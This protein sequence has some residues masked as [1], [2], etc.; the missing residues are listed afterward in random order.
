MLWLSLSGG[1]TGGGVQPRVWRLRSAQGRVNAPSPPR[2][3]PPFGPESRKCRARRAER[4]SP[5]SPVTGVLASS[6]RPSGGCV[7]PASSTTAGEGVAGRGRSGSGSRRR[8]EGGAW[9]GRKAGPERREA[10]EWAGV[11][12]LSE[13]RRR[14]SLEKAACNA[15]V[16]S[17]GERGLGD[18]GL[19]SC[20]R[21]SARARL[22]CGMPRGSFGKLFWPECVWADSGPRTAL[23]RVWKRRCHPQEGSQKAGP[24]LMSQAGNSGRPL[25]A[26]SCRAD[27]LS[28]SAL[29]PGLYLLSSSSGRVSTPRPCLQILAPLDTVPATT[30]VKV[31][32]VLENC[33]Y[34]VIAEHMWETVAVPQRLLEEIVG[35]EGMSLTIVLTTHHLWDHTQGNVEP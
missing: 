27:G 2:P 22:E 32:L 10:R 35:Q 4:R 3:R 1:L 24:L 6:T 29:P 5:S 13:W 19:A 28:P 31:I 34:L 21:W 25:G 26:L 23:F 15:G 18:K 17:E 8:G 7:T 33:M 14:G 11:G 20:T 12:K 16:G 30:K 9:G